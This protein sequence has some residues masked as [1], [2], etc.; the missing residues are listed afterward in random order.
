MGCFGDERFQKV[1]ALRSCNASRIDCYTHHD[2][3]WDLCSRSRGCVLVD[4][5][6]SVNKCSDCWNGWYVHWICA[7]VVFQIRSVHWWTRWNWN[8]IR[9]WRWFHCRLVSLRNSRTC[10]GTLQLMAILYLLGISKGILT[11][12]FCWRWWYIFLLRWPNTI[13]KFWT[14]ATGVRCHTCEHQQWEMEWLPELCWYW[15]FLL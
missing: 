2:Y 6:N 5:F 9:S 13:Q 1:R 3:S 12:F 8:Q 4:F 14:S 7:L 10:E 15:L 11:V